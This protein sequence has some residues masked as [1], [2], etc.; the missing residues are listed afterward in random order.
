MSGFIFK[1]FISLASIFSFSLNAYA[2]DCSQFPMPI[3]TTNTITGQKIK[4][5]ESIQVGLKNTSDYDYTYYIHMSPG[6]AKEGWVEKLTRQTLKAHETTLKTVST[7]S[8]TALGKHYLR[9]TVFY[10]GPGYEPDCKVGER[11]F[12]FNVVSASSSGSTGG[13]TGGS[14]GGGAGGGTGGGTGGSAGGGT[15]SRT[16]DS[17]DSSTGGG[18]NPERLTFNIP[19]LFGTQKLEGEEQNK[20][21]MVELLL[22]I[23]GKMIEILQILAFLAVVY[24]GIMYITA[25]GNQEAAEKAK[26]NLTWAL[27]GIII[28]ILSYLIVEWV[29]NILSSGPI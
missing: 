11:D 1:T 29:K 25:S 27:T 15:G 8:T 2:T 10:Y 23:V 9:V 22:R 28:T 5:G 20:N 3:I 24:S 6:A 16:D 14:T 19:D 18:E 26:K 21:W 12:E 4:Q 17:G 7:T 13:G